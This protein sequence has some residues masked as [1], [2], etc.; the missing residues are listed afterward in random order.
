MTMA[1]ALRRGQWRRGWAEYECALQG[2]LIPRI[3]RS[4]HAALGRF[5]TSAAAGTLLILTE[6]GLGDTIHR[7]VHPAAARRF[8]A[9]A[10]PATRI[11]G[12]C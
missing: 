8:G 10:L 11:Y 4:R 2:R 6:Q 1:A 5:G 3:P 9:R 7:A 12:R